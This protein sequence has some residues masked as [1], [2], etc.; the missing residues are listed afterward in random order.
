MANRK[1]SRQ[2]VKTPV[3]LYSKLFGD[4]IGTS[5]DI[6]DSG[7]SIDIEPFVALQNDK[8][9]K[10]VF[11]NSINKRVIFN[12]KF[13]RETEHGLAFRFIDYET[14]GQRYQLEDLRN[15]WGI[16]KASMDHVAA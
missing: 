12:V 9:Q 2:A 7:I 14:A 8:E 5:S 11:I 6:S 1:S 16:H 4:F 15:M 3:K 10:L 13:V